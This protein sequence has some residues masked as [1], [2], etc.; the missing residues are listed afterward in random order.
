V[1][2]PGLRALVLAAGF[3]TRLEP[4][5]RFLPK[6]LLPVAGEPVIGHTLRQLGRLGCEAA[7][8]NLHH[9]ADA[10]PAELGRSHWGLPLVYSREREILGT[11][12]ALYPCRDFLAAAEAIL[13]LNG[14]TLCRWPLKALIERHRRSSAAATLLLHERSPEATLGGGVGVD[15]RG[16]V[17]QLRDAEAVATVR[18]RHVFAGAQVLSP[19]LVERLAA[20]PG[21]VIAGLYQPLLREGATIAAEVFSGPWFDLGTPERYLEAALGWRP[22]RWRSR[23]PAQVSRL[24]H[25]APGA[26]IR[27]ALIDREATVAAGAVVEDSVVLAG[28][29]VP[30][31]CIL[32]SSL[33][34]PG[35]T[36]APSTHL[37]RR[38]IN[39]M[40]V[41]YSPRAAE[42]VI[43]ELVYSPLE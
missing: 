23:P 33:V 10:I 21:D 4:L 36:L 8:V 42:S 6:P 14:D 17:V 35:A 7:A 32:R 24:A 9:L 37:H 20:G 29:T 15:G 16:R 40:P 31:G 22:G 12:G 30:A 39:R 26:T 3:G 18:R 25:L 5:T 41:G 28:A 34:G 43:G 38:M 27:N 1:S 13:V 11:L 2:S 19:A